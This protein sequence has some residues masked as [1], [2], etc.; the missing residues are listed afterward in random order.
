MAPQRRVEQAC[1]GNYTEGFVAAYERTFALRSGSLGGL[2]S[3][4]RRITAW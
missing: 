3:V 2:Q 4:I 1:G